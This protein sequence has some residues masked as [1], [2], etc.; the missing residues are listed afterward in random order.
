MKNTR[1]N[2]GKHKRTHENLRIT[3]LRVRVSVKG[4]HSPT[5]LHPHVCI[6]LDGGDVIVLMLAAIQFCISGYVFNLKVMFSK[7][8]E[9]EGEWG[10]G[11]CEGEGV[12]G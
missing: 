5:P 9:G 2:P 7:K 11:G 10:E 1:E 8:G 6:F 12:G 3:I 4:R